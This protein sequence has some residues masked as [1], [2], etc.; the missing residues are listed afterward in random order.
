[1]TVTE[2][3]LRVGIVEDEA[4][5]RSVLTDILNAEPNIEVLHA[6]DGFEQGKE[7]L[8][9][10]SVD[11]A[12]VDVD[13]GDGNGVALA[14]QLQRADPRLSV[15][16]LSGHDV[17]DLVLSVRS[18]VARPWSYLSKRT[19]LDRTTLV[20]AIVATA[21]GQVVLDPALMRRSRPA[22]DSRL[23]ALTESQMAV[24]RLVAEGF[25][26]QAVADLLG[27]SPRSVENH[28]VSIYKQLGV[29]SGDSNPRVTAVLSFLQQSSRY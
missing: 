23:A 29:G 12:V 18:Q 20:R 28:L 22:D 14:V 26:N 10:G 6:A 7:L 4:L 13:L 9:P 16:L 2:R 8:A 11:I 19:S 17:M 27:L 25:S 15:L 3:D 24:L 5:M 21:R 1:M